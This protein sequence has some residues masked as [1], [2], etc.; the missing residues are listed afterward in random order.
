MDAFMAL[1][2]G[3]FA[4]MQGQGRKLLSYHIIS[5]VGYMVAAIGIGSELAINAASWH[6]VNNVI[7][8]SILFM[9]ICAAMY[10][11]GSED[12][13][14]MGGLYKKMP[15]TTACVA[16]AALSI[17]GVP[18]FAGFTS[19]SLVF[20]AVEHAHNVPIELI[21]E[22]AAVATFLSF[23]KFTYF[24][25]LKPNK[26]F[27]DTAKEAPIFMLIP[28]VTLSILA[29]ITG[30]FPN[31]VAGILP[32][33][34]ELLTHNFFAFPTVLGSFH[35]MIPIAIAYVVATRFFEPHM[36]KIRDFDYLYIKVANYVP[37][38]F[39][40]GRKIDT[41]INAVYQT[42][43]DLLPCLFKLVRKID[44][45]VNSLYIAITNI[46]KLFASFAGPINNYLEQVSEKSEK[47]LNA[48]KKPVTFINGLLS[49]LLMASWVDLWLYSPTTD[50][51]ATETK[52]LNQIIKLFTKFSYKISS[53]ANSLEKNVI[54]K[55]G[56]QLS[57]I[58]FNSKISEPLKDDVFYENIFSEKVKIFDETIVDGFINGISA[59]V[60]YVGNN[61]RKIQTGFVQNYALIIVFVVAFLVFILSIKGGIL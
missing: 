55:T 41:G 35:L 51:Q 57:R 29:L 52:T 59:I 28:M 46:P 54:N 13:T 25:F 22:V 21:L 53:I 26:E 17:T 3:M 6:L 4:L 49:N 14:K 9:G 33:P 60:F 24:G 19:K 1:F 31:F 18:L 37:S 5:Q 39:E 58:L 20:E 56:E 12:L 42:I 36:R 50:S 47:F 43:A 48:A 45:A 32:Y 44:N 2:G 23:I 7:Y 15:I 30:L 40:F 34:K 61:I 8:K 16:I 11:T 10:R 27:G 38:L